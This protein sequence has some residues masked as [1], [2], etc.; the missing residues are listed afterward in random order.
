VLNVPLAWKSFW[1]LLMEL[2]GDVGQVEACFSTFG[3]SVNLAQDRCI[4]WDE[5][6]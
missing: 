6:P 2:L 1:A 4:V 3:D 5:L